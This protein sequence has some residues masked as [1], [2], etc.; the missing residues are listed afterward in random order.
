MTDPKE[1]VAASRP[2]APP[3]G[4]VRAWLQ[5]FGSF[6]VFFNIWYIQASFAAHN[7]TNSVMTAGVLS[8]PLEISSLTTKRIY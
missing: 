1:E 2:P 3:N 4:G 8:S 6:L 5:V 7:H